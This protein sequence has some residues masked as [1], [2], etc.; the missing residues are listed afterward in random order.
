MLTH[1]TPHQSLSATALPKRGKPELTETYIYGRKQETEHPDGDDAD[2]LRRCGD[3]HLRAL[4]RARARR[5]HRDGRLS[6]RTL[7]RHAGSRRHPPRHAATAHEKPACGAPLPCRAEKAA[8]IRAVRRGTRAR[9]HPRVHLRLAAKAAA[10]PLC[11]HG[12][13]GLPRDA[14]V[15]A[16]CQLG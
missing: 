8:R 7:C 10:L 9:A 6:R 15:E 1:P 2:G 3:A 14:A 5:P 11:H 13:L 16:A 12:A 4:P